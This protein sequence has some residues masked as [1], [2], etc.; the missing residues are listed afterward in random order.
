VKETTDFIRLFKE[1]SDINATD[2]I[3]LSNQLS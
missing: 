2:S 1:L 3:S